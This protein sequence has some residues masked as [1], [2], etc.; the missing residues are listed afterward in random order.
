M[1]F[2]AASL[3]PM[4]APGVEVIAGLTHDPL[5]GS[6]VVFGLGGVFVELFED[7]AFRVIPLTDRD[8]TEMIEATRAGRLLKGFRGS[9]PADVAAVHDLLLRLA[10]LAD[11]APR[12]LELDLNPV[13]V[14]SEG[15]G[16]TIVDAR[17]KLA[18]PT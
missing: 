8:A 12:I 7:V 4:A 1:K 2:I 10:A 11:A 5:F 17:V 16:F 14:H 18:E 3:S 15:Q 9:A 13:I 6:L